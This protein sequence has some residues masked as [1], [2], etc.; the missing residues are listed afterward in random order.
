MGLVHADCNVQGAVVL[1]RNYRDEGRG[2]FWV[3]RTLKCPACGARFK[4]IEMSEQDFQQHHVHGGDDEAEGVP[5][6]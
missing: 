6:D 3:S 1:T 4:S 5:P 2:Y